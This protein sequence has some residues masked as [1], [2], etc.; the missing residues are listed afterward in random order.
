MNNFR[1][2]PKL[3]DKNE[4]PGIH[5]AIFNSIL[6]CDTDKRKDLYGNIIL[7]GSG[8]MFNGIVERLTREITLLAPAAVNIKV[9]GNPERRDSVWIGGSIL[10]STDTF[11]SVMITR[12][13][14]D[15][16]GPSIVHRKCF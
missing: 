14:Y 2:K 3:I 1:I 11:Q 6:K 13:D 9:V 8:T 4:S 5:E 16:W 7:S 10:A 15:E 12:A